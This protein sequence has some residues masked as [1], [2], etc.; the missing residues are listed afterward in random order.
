MGDLGNVYEHFLKEIDNAITL[1]KTIVNPDVPICDLYF[2]R[3][4]TFFDKRVILEEREHGKYDL[5]SDAVLPF[6][7][8]VFELAI[9]TL[10]NR[11]DEAIFERDL[12]DLQENKDKLFIKKNVLRQ[13]Y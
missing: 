1:I 6:V 5:E 7:I 8:K 2:K 12:I 4:Y 10:I 11:E 13:T 9:Y 3:P